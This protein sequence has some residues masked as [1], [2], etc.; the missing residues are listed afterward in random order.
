MKRRECLQAAVSAVLVAMGTAST[1][2]AKEKGKATSPAT[3]TASGHTNAPTLAVCETCGHVE[4]GSPPEFC[5]VCNSEERFQRRDT[6]FSDAQSKL[7]DGGNKHAP[8][9]R[10][11]QKS[12]LVADVPCKEVLVRVGEVM[13]ETDVANH[14]HFVD[15]YLD[16]R[17]F[18][19]FFAAPQMQPAVVLF[20]R[21][22]AAKIR[23]VSFCSQHGFWQSEVPI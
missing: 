22:S 18:T 11:Q 4:F 7:K 1:A 6:I 9:I 17:F 23:A 15:F 5:P 8:V 12:S 10:V 21:A 16:G 20:V 19:R 2:A 14:I 13:H 3:T